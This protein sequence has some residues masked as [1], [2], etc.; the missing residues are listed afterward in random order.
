MSKVGAVYVLEPA[1]GAWS[2]GTETF[3]ADDMSSDESS[4]S[5]MTTDSSAGGI[6]KPD[7]LERASIGK[8]GLTSPDMALE[9][10]A[11]VTGRG[12]T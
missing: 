9:A 2:E 10:A 8:I 11:A 1:G 4:S 7:A 3:C 12:S 5:L 6:S